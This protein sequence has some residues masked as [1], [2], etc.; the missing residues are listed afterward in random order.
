MLRQFLQFQRFAKSIPETP[1]SRR[2]SKA[3]ALISD[4]IRNAVRLLGAA[5]LLGHFSSFESGVACQDCSSAR[6][7][8]IMRTTRRLA[9]AL[10]SPL[11][12]ADV[13]I[14]PHG[15][16]LTIAPAPSGPCRL[17]QTCCKGDRC[18]YD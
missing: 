3:Y 16:Y 1:R 18:R 10:K 4:T 5:P 15:L 17:G 12:S 2:K 9:R 14:F 7:A 13:A 6:I 8:S 11:P